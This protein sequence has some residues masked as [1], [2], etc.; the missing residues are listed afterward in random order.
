MQ[1]SESKIHHSI[2]EKIPG[3]EIGKVPTPG[4][5]PINIF[6]HMS[7]VKDTPDDTSLASHISEYSITSAPEGRDKMYN[8]YTQYQEESTIKKDSFPR[9][10]I[11]HQIQNMSPTH[12]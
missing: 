6:A 11:G 7:D 8:D 2:Q 1:N 12:P 10:V 3:K 5:N 9:W 4:R